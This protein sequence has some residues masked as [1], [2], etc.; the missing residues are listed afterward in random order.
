MSC[1]S[2]FPFPAWSEPGA[3]PETQPALL[4][5]GAGRSRCHEHAADAPPGSVVNGGLSFLLLPVSSLD[6]G[7]VRRRRRLKGE[8]RKLMN[9]KNGCNEGV[10]VELEGNRLVVT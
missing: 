9:L 3:N 8:M 4:W 5:H 1:H 6:S 2:S 10:K 7:I